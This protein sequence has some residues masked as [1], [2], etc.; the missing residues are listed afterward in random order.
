M[1]YSELREIG[2]VASNQ[3]NSPAIRFRGF[4][5]PWERK[6]FGDFGYVAMCKRVMKYQTSEKG[7]VPFYKIGTF[8]HQADAFISYTLFSELKRNYQYPQKGDILISAAGT[9][10]RTVE[11]S[12]NEEYFQD[13]NIVWLN[14]SGSLYNP[15]LKVLYSTVTWNSVE[16]STLKRLY[17]NNILQTK[18]HV[19][20]YDEQQKIGN[21]FREQDE[22]INAAGQQISK[23]KTLKQACLQQMFV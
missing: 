13:S 9:L 15:F 21:F 5:E 2:L 10:G 8:G 14:H 7:D 23:L 20:S 4:T 18:I 1:I 17:N 19:P 22:S 3:P 16:G 12:G 6:T 11:F